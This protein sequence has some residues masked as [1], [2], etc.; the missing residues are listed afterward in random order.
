MALSD[1]RIIELP[2]IHDSRGNLSVVEAGRQIPFDIK[3]VY[4]L[5]DIPGGAVR[6]GHAHRQLHQIMIAMSGA[7]D[8]TLDDGK[9]RKKF[10]LNR[11]YVGLYIAPMTWRDLDNFSSGAVCMNI[12][13]EYYDE[14]DYMRTYDEFLQEIEKKR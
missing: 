7:F 8:V 6:A 9:E 14:A 13:S 12:A 3:R 11:S 1:C 4:Y 5:Y 2:K 10:H